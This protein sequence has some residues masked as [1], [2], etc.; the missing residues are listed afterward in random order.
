[1]RRARFLHD[2]RLVQGVLKEP[3]VLQ[4]AAGRAYADDGVR[5]LP[6]VEPTKVIA[7]ALN[8]ADHATEVE[9]AVPEEPALFFKS[10]NTW[11]GHREPVVYPA[12]ARYVHH[13]VELA[14]AIGTRCRRVSG[15][16]AMEMVGGYTIANDLVIRDY[17]TNTF[18][19][20]LRGK[21]WDT[22][23]PL[24]PYLVLDE[25]ENPHDL[26]LRAYVNG[27]LRQSGT[28]ADM[29]RSIPELIEYVTHFMTLEA[30]DLILTGTP[31]GVSHIYPGDA[32]RLEVDGLGALEN[33]VI[34]DEA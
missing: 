24:G 25:I 21:C 13:E 34:P 9:L 23:C 14:V 32:M 26:G 2:G 11:V 33:A 17:V 10:A 5:F 7:L 27:E 31:R 4:D 18:R 6:P 12:G 3:G 29:I 8:Y 16:R 30:G 19:P 22:F 28:T 1:M 20:P 15:T